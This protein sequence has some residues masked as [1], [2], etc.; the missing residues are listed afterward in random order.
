MIG[1][2]WWVNVSRKSKRDGF[3]CKADF[4]R[5]PNSQIQ[6]EIEYMHGL[7]AAQLLHAS[8]MADGNLIVIRFRVQA[9]I[10]G[11]VTAAF[12]RTRSDASAMPEWSW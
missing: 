7:A 1:M 2:L 6:A 9:D 11:M 3:E 8:H 4:L 12:N 10:L 5:L